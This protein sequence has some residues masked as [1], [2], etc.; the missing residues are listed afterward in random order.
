MHPVVRGKISF[1]AKFVVFL[2]LF[3]GL[4]A[5][6]PVNDRVIVPFTAAITRAAA[7]IARGFDRDVTATGTTIA[8]GRFAMDVKNGCNAVETM[9]LFIAAILAFPAPARL[10]LVALLIGLPAIQL[11]NLVRL[12]SLFWLGTT[13]PEWFNIFHVAIWQSVIIL[14]GVAMFA[15]W[16]SRVAR[17]PTAD[18]G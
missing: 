6:Y 1:A 5:F 7:S 13:R 16:S 4:V 8:S 12:T 15:I 14:I 2:V 9:I 18:R 17:Q 11:A 3:Y 10:R